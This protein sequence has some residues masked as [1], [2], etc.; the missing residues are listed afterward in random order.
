MF[1]KK[2][3]AALQG[4][5]LTLVMVGVVL[6]VGFVVMDNLTAT[7]TPGSAAA[8]ASIAVSAALETVT[9]YLPIIVIVAVLGIVMAY[10][11]GWLGGRKKG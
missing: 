11:M 2:G 4:V 5:V 8:N 6:V 1:H 3:F 7:L 9:T 10:L